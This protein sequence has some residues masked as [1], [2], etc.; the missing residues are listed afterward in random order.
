MCEWLNASSEWPVRLEKCFI[1]FTF[2]PFFTESQSRVSSLSLQFFRRL[3]I[4]LTVIR[5]Q[6][7]T[8]WS[9]NLLIFSKN[10]QLPPSNLQSCKKKHLVCFCL[11][12][13]SILICAKGPT[14]S[15]LHLLSAVSC[16]ECMAG[17]LKQ[18]S[19]CELWFFKLLHQLWKNI[20]L[21][22]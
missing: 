20:L 16:K 10:Y 5:G 21:I 3:R 6:F 18:D 4:I 14:L 22:F 15:V 2:T 17:I 12:I 8:C 11:P 13:S 9:F 19:P 1:L 7:S